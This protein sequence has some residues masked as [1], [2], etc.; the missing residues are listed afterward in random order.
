MD[1]SDDFF[2]RAAKWYIIYRFL[3]ACFGM[4]IGMIVG[5]GFVIYWVCSELSLESSYRSRYGAD[6]QAEFE[7]YHGSLSHAHTQIA[8]GVTCLLAIVAVLTWFCRVTF[9][10]HEHSRHMHVV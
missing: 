3:W 2:D 6:W 4:I 1:E 9:H 8:I 7:K 5:V 10:K